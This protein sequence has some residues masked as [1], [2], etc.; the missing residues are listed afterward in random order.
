LSRIGL[1]GGCFDPPHEGHLRLAEL[2]WEILGLDALRFVPAA[3][4]PGKPGAG[5]PAEVR[6]RLLRSALAGRPWSLDPIELDRGGTSYTVET[7][8][9]LAGREPGNAWILLLGFDQAAAFASWHQPE[10]IL[11]L[12]S[13]AVA[14]RPGAA[15][16]LPA[17]L[18]ARRAEA[19]SGA[20]GELVLLPSTGLALSSADLRASLAR[21]EAPQGL[22][23]QVLA[24]ILA[25][26]LYR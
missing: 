24:A 19:W 20:P 16:A 25:E 23:P 12:A 18:L 13:L 11:E 14:A 9:T 4:S 22:P 5:P 15:T 7:L 17:E 21:G 3:R 10:R 2:A 26:N 8:A 1:L 6:L